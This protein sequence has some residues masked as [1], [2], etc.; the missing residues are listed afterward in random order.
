MHLVEPECASSSLTCA[1]EV[2][3]LIT[4]ITLVCTILKHSLQFCNT[5]VNSSF[6]FITWLN[7]LS[8]SMSPGIT[9]LWSLS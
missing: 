2:R 4:G 7:K 3:T 5:V 8:S 9:V 1:R 6:A